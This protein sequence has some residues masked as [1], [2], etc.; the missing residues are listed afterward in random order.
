LYSALSM[1]PKLSDEP[2]ACP[3]CGCGEVSFF[4]EQAVAPV[5]QRWERDWK[6]DVTSCFECIESFQEQTCNRCRIRFYVPGTLAGPPGLY[7]QLGGPEYY[8]PDKWEYRVALEDLNAGC[9]VLEVGCGFGEFLS[10]ARRAGIQAEGLE[11]NPEAL[12]E[13]LRRGLDARADDFCSLAAHSPGAYDGIC[14]FQVLEHVPN[15][16]DFLHAACKALSEG[17]RLVLAVPNAESFLRHAWNILDMPPHHMTRWSI[18]AMES[19]ERLFP[20]RLLRLRVE[21]LANYHIHDYV[22]A[23]FSA[24]SAK[25]RLRLF[26]HPAAKSATAALIRGMALRHLLRGHTLYACFMRVDAK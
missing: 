2:V 11:Q 8:R 1:L 5:V 6:I 16:G 24:W 12:R 17:G 25:P 13:T 23:Y 14:M 4:R 15:P 18:A 20:L 21:P 10:L 26:S 9:R 3:L 22:E 19:I 7:A